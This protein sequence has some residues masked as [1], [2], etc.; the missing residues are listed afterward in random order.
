MQ[1]NL[2]IPENLKIGFQNRN[3]TY[4]GKLAYVTYYNKDKLAKECSWEGWRDKD[5]EPLELENKPVSGFVINKNV[6]GARESYG[7]NARNEYARVYD[8]RGFEFE[9]SFGNLLFILQEC[10]SFKGKGLE[11]DFVYSWDG[12]NLVLLP[13][14]S[15]EYKESLKYTKLQTKKIERNQWIEG[16]TYLT[17]K[18]EKVIYLGRKYYGEHLCIYSKA[19]GKNKKVHVFARLDKNNCEPYL[20][21]SGFTN[22]AEIIDEKPSPSWCI[23]EDKWNKEF[24]SAPIKS[25]ELIKINKEKVEEEIKKGAKKLTSN[26]CRYYKQ[27][28]FIN[29]SNSFIQI[30]DNEIKKVRFYGRKEDILESSKELKQFYIQTFF[31][32]TVDK[33]TDIDKFYKNYE[34]MKTC[35]YRG[36]Y[37]GYNYHALYNMENP[38]METVYE[39]LDNYY[40][41][42]VTNEKGIKFTIKD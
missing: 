30:K 14:D 31:N 16:A 7:W 9:I 33:I 17:K 10:N 32:S 39:I 42:I 26:D 41:L 19:Y 18:R 23:Y 8:P 15:T 20:K 36:C 22:I 3:D 4:T 5:I 28:E 24:C 6:G 12:K 25:I 13:A 34:K 38:N 21:E 35:N 1:T 29:I 40:Q 37:S 11:G 27:D 2:K